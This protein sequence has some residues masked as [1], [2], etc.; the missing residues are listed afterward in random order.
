[1]YNNSSFRIWYI[2]IYATNYLLATSN[3]LGK[4]F[5]EV[6]ETEQY[7]IIARKDSSY[8]KIEDVKGKDIYLNRR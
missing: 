8:N 6:T 5:R 7:Y 4:V 3:F 2:Y 1:M